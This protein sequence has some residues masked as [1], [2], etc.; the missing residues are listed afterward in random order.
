VQVAERRSAAAVRMNAKY[1][2]AWTKMSSSQFRALVRFFGND[3]TRY[4]PKQL[5]T[6]IVNGEQGATPSAP[7]SN[8]FD[9]RDFG[10][11]IAAA[12]AAMLAVEVI[13]RGRHTPA[14]EG[15]HGAA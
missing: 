6:F 10:I 9:F 14:L 5:K 7:S 3:V 13:R 15:A 11:G 2:N 4:S 8:G 12:I 1:G